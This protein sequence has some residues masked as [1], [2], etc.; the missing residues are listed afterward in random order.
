M[1]VSMGSTSWTLLVLTLVGAAAN[2]DISDSSGSPGSDPP[3]TVRSR[4]RVPVRRVLYQAGNSANPLQARWFGQD[5]HDYVGPNNQFKPSEVQD[6]R[7][8]LAGLDPR[9][10][11]VFVEVNGYGGDQWQFSPKSPSWT[12]GFRRSKAGRTAELFLEPYRVETGRGFQIVVRYDDGS[13]VEVWAKGGKADP[14][15]R[16]PNAA[17]AARWIGQDRQDWVGSGPSV[18]PDGLQDVRI[19][20]SKISAKAVIKALRIEGPAG[21]GWEFG[22]NP[23]LLRNAEFFRDPKDPSQGDVFFQ[24]DRDL[25]AQR[26]K[27]TILYEND[28][29]DS[30]SVAAGRCDPKLRMTPA[31]LPRFVDWKVQARWLG[32]DGGIAP[33]PGDVQVALSGLPTTLPIVGAV[34]SDTVR[35]V[36]IYRADEHV[37]IPAVPNS[38]PL[39]LK[40]HSNRTSADLFFGP[41]RV[42]NSDEFTL[43]L[44]FKDGQNSLVQFP[45]G[46][47]DLS[48]RGPRPE[49]SRVEAK[50]GDDIQALVDRYGTVSLAKGTYRLTRPLVLSRPVTLTSEGGATLVFAQPA[51]ESSWT[52]AIKLHCGNT[53]LNGFAVRFEGPIRWNN[54]VSWGP[55]IIGMTDALDHGHNE[56]RMN[57]V[58][59]RLDLEVPPVENSGGWVEAIRLMRLLG[60][61]N[62]AIAENILRG[63]TIEFFDGPWRIVDNDFRGTP[64]GTISHG[65][66]TGHGTHDLLVRGNRTRALEASGKTWR[67]LVLTGASAHDIVERNIIEQVGARDDD[68]IPWSN[69]PEIILTES[70]HVKY[71]GKLLDR[72]KD[73]R[74]IR[75]G[76]PQGDEGRTG[77]LVSLLNGPAAGQWRR[78]V[79]MID[80]NTY[81]VDSPIPTGTEVVSISQGFVS[82]VFQENRIDLRGGRRSCSF[83]LAGNH[84]GT[85]VI[86]NHL[87]GGGALCAIAYPTESPM[88]WGWTHAPFL[89]A[90]IEG[91][92]FEDNQVGCV[93]AVQHDPRHIKSNLGRTYMTVAVNNNV[94]RWSESFLGH[95]E[96]AESKEPLMGLTIGGEHSHDAGELVVVAEGNRLEAPPRRRV[97]PSLLIHAADYNSKR[98]VNRKLELPSKATAEP[99]RRRETSTRSSSPPR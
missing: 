34:L 19:H 68:T 58:L 52:T 49:P 71:E 55:A 59:T 7:I 85:R 91:N 66:F 97:G 53:T 43:R 82:E 1:E 22:S 45:G 4:D 73:G 18:G 28:R 21:I 77:D 2:S 74:L 84:F 9:R 92:I 20:L 41:Y 47:C 51:T 57:V 75:I 25:S 54:E 35:G 83:V 31:P 37:S 15:L 60:A 12:D 93:V 70:Y 11:V 32:Q 94:V 99:N 6:I 16:M 61:R 14:N 96:H 17:L 23:K 8:G 62:G 95:R 89:G 65:V 90:V 38:E 80:P 86:E 72:S 40:V 3:E 50:P 30:A 42:A 63:G 29:L 26:L 36:W 33:R 24:A 69:E 88:I 79:Q 87:F 5:G 78:I 76:R 56:L 48:L 13:T 27:V 67:F 10:E 81:L 46:R 98:I 44:I 39:E 64:P